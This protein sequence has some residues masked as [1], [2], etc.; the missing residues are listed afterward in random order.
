MAPRHILRFGDETSYYEYFIGR[1]SGDRAET[2]LIVNS[3]VL[4][5]E[6]C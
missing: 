3:D 4:V 5:P 1:E 6:F 2:R